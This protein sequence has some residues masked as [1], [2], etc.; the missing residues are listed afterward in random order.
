MIVV[1]IRVPFARIAALL[2]HNETQDG[3][4][5]PAVRMR[6]DWLKLFAGVGF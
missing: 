2:N 5:Y 4:A 1:T 3:D 6:S